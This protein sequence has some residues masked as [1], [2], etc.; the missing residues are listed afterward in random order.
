MSESRVQTAVRKV[1][2][3]RKLSRETRTITSRAQSMVL[4]ELSETELAEA[5]LLLSD[6]EGSN[7]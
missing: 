3:L 4:R 2:A 7:V 1:I 5:A 6:G